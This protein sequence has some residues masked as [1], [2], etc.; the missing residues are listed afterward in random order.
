M[1]MNVIYIYIYDHSYDIHLDFRGHICACINE[2]QI[3]YFHLITTKIRFQT[4]IN[5][6]F[7]CA[8]QLFWRNQFFSPSDCVCTLTGFARAWMLL[9]IFFFFVRSNVLWPP[10]PPPIFLSIYA[11]RPHSSLYDYITSIFLS[12]EVTAVFNRWLF[13]SSFFFFYLTMYGASL[14][15]STFSMNDMS[16]R[17]RR[18]I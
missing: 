10:P 13:S 14:F 8:V 17:H 16:D 5:R 12:L 11:R 3:K 6:F 4:W 1:L 7:L 9:L 18:C 2:T 15:V